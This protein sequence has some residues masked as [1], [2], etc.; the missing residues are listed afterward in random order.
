MLLDKLSLVPN[1]PGC[2]LMKNQNGIIIYI[3]KAKKLKN[4][5]N[6][7]FHSSHTG[8]TAKLISEIV[9]FDYIVVSSETESLILENN[10]IKKYDPKYNILLRDDKTYPYIE[11]TKE[12]I[13]RLS[14]VRVL[15]KKNNKS[16]LFGPYPNVSAAR[17]L[18]NLL[19]RLYPLKK[20][21]TYPKKPC[22]YYHIGQCLGY[23][24]NK[25]NQKEIEKME[26][27]IISFLN[28]NTIEIN[29]KIKKQIEVESNKLNYEKAKELNDIYQYINIITQKQKVEINN[30]IN[31]DVFGYYAN[32]DYL[33]IQVFF[34]RNSK[35]VERHYKILPLI[36]EIETEFIQYI[37]N[38]YKSNLLPKM[39]LVPN[40]FDYSLLTSYLNI[41]IKIPLRGIKKSIVEMANNNAKLT[42]NNKLKLIIKEEQH[43]IKTNQDLQQL[44][45]LNQLD[46][47]EIFD[48]S[49]LFGTFNVSGMV[50]FENGKPNKK[51]YRK[52]KISINKNDDYSTMKEVIY[53]RY[54][55]VLMDNLKQPDLII[56]DG[57]VGQI[58]IARETLKSLNLFIPVIGLK[59]DKKHNTNTLM[60]FNP[61]EEIILKKNSDLFHY[62]ER[63]QNEVHN[64]TI[65]YHKKIRSKGL[66]ESKL[67]KIS[68]IGPK[69][70]EQLLKKYGSIEN[71]QKASI[72]ELSTILPKKAIKELKK[73]F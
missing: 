40:G 20:C 23:C 11:L 17:H 18:V 19:N 16:R 70:K 2:Y 60:A 65:N 15:N 63:M 58:N 46:R 28:G 42:L 38:F 73:H 61:I 51:E 68:Y 33:S 22:L 21:K 53:R 43:T 24:T 55:R 57:S 5:L 69:R 54:Y 52:Y 62:L 50:V 66:I 48:N 32:N 9:D 7:Y 1:L 14:I 39:I 12:K 41:N 67:D 13:P 31:I 29:K 4:R 49:N 59:K 6:S 10:L 35:I 44:L 45:H 8:K 26:K 47:I 25:V 27:Q 30:S 72:S 56:V 3:G 34:I 64:F 36:D 71:I 37:I